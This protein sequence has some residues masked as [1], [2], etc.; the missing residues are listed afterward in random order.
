MTAQQHEGVLLDLCVSGAA[1]RM[2]RRVAALAREDPRLRIVGAL[3]AP[4]S[5]AL[6]RDLGTLCGGEPMGV[7]LCADPAEATGGAAVVVD[8]SLPAALPGLLRAAAAAGAAVVSGTTG[9]QAAQ[10]AAVEEAALR[11]PVLVAPNFSLGIAVLRALAERAARWLGPAFDLELVELHH[12]HKVDAPS[13]TA[14]SLAAALQ[15][16]RPEATTRRC[17]REGHVGARGAEEI[18]VAALRGG[19]A[20][21]EHTVYL[22]GAGE[23]LELTHRATSRD[24]FVHGALRAARW[25]VEQP[26]GRYAL[27]DLLGD[28]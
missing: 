8:F 17:G 27:V 20:V 7:L 6:G 15:Q 4:G 28:P 3:D 24:I 16:A 19:D 2:G 22:L 23:R 12:R 26:P 21:G 9:L 11:V 1:G 10:E 18:G 25:L 5:P 14:L 13:G